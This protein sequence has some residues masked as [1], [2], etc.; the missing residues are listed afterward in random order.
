MEVSTWIL[1]ISAP[2]MIV[3]FFY[4]RKQAQFR[5]I[6]LLG[7]SCPRCAHLCPR[8]AKRPLSAK[9][10]GA[11]GRARN[12]VARSTGTVGNEIGSPR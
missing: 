4:V 11:G 2:A 6:G 10:C 3:A 7:A 8:I 12:A 9:H 5:G 1:L